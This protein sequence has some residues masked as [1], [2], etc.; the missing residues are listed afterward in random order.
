MILAIDIGN[1]T[2]T[3]GLYDPD[4]S[5][6]FRSALK[7]DKN[8]TRDQMAIDLLDVFHL[9]RED[10]TGVT[11]AIISSVV[12]P[13]TGDMAAAVQLLTGKTPMIVGPGTKTGMNI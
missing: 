4:G 9:Y 5:L 11:G 10:V 3:L 8:K 7:T 6:R 2:L 13:M 12:P 1:T